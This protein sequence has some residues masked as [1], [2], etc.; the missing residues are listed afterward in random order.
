MATPQAIIQGLEGEV[1]VTRNGEIVNIK[2]GDFLLP[3]DVVETGSN[4][5]LSLEFPG[6]DGQNPAA[7]VMTGNGKITL[8]EQPGATGQQIVVI[9]ETDCF[10]FTTEL[11]EDSAAASKEAGG[12][13]GDFAGNGAAIAG[14]GASAAGLFAGSNDPSSN[15]ADGTVSPA[16]NPGGD[17]GFQPGSYSSE[18]LSDPQ[19]LIEKVVEDV[20]Q[21]AESS[22]NGEGGTEL[23]GNPV[24]EAFDPVSAETGIPNP[25]NETQ[26]DDELLAQLTSGGGEAPSTDT[27]IETLDS[28]IVTEVVNTAADVVSP[29]EELGPV[30]DTAGDIATEIDDVLGEVADGLAGVVN[31]LDAVTPEGDG[32]PEGLTLGE[33]DLQGE[34]EGL[35]GDASTLQSGL[36]NSGGGDELGLTEGGLTGINS[37]AGL[38]DAASIIDPNAGGLGS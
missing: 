29:I 17:P 10:E 30:M 16:G 19:S 9:E 31:E 33:G 11:T 5:R 27:I 8:G 20:E 21:T 35:I 1:S 23:S 15:G 3:G 28:G 22:S 14:V 12:F 34:A 6:V 24:A 37:G 7:G 18:D 26:A 38:D 13:F 25:F 32:L 2:A 4:G 36:Q